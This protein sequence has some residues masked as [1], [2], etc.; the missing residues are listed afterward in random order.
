[1][2]AGG[3][4]ERI[5]VRAGL[6]GISVAGRLSGELARYLELLLRWNVRMNLTGLR[7]DDAG[8][9]RLIVEPLVAAGRLGGGPLRLID[10]GSG[11]GSPAIPMRLACPDVRL[12][13]VERKGRKAAFL[14][15]AVR[16]LT[17]RGA[18]V[19]AR[20]F[21]ELGSGLGEEARADVVT[22]RAVKFGEPGFRA[23]AGMLASGGRVF[24]FEGRESGADDG[25][26]AGFE[27]EESLPLVESLQSRLLILRKAD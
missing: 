9:D 2:E 6:A 11:G 4:S 22:V 19:E 3:L 20:G 1:M 23:V 10:I 27:V 24:L 26:A 21:E 5:A 14:R 16:Q 13:M 8:V 17:L 18:S 7:D 25:A 15:E 12:R